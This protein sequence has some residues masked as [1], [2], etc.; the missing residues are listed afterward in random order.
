MYSIEYICFP[1]LLFPHFKLNR[2]SNLP[3]YSSTWFSK[4]W[5]PVDANIV[6]KCDT[7][8]FSYLLVWGAVD[9]GPCEA[10]GGGGVELVN[11]AQQQ[12]IAGWVTSPLRAVGLGLWCCSYGC[13]R[14]NKRWNVT[15]CCTYMTNIRHHKHL[16]SSSQS[17]LTFITTYKHSPKHKERTTNY[18]LQKSGSTL[19]FPAHITWTTNIYFCEINTNWL[20][21]Y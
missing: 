1:T 13:Q 6:Q 2:F 9:L 5:Q 14:H 7:G 4:S 21:L 19:I 12:V 20:L 3:S 10:A 16:Y 8:L 18:G 17:I 11:P 15:M